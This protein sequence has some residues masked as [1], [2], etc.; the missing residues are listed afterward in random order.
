M[1]CSTL[2]EMHKAEIDIIRS[3]LQGWLLIDLCGKPYEVRGRNQRQ[4]CFF[5]LY[6]LVRNLSQ[7]IQQVL[8]RW[9]C[10]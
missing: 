6:A 9:L 2:Y 8:F 7:E 4:C 3:F 1:E 10:F 5:V